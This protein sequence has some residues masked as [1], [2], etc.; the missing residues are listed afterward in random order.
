MCSLACT[1]SE[2]SSGRK[3][4]VAPDW[5][6]QDLHP[7]TQDLP[8]LDV[9]SGILQSWK[10]NLLLEAPP[11][12][13][14][15]TIVP[16]AIYHE[17]QQQNSDDIPPNV[18]V[19]E[20]RRVAVRSAATRMAQLLNEPVG[21]TVGYA[22]RGEAKI[23]PTKTRIIVMTDGVLLNRLQQDPELEG[24]D[25]VILDEFHERGVGSDTCLA[26]CR[27]AQKLFRRDLQ[28]VVM[29]ATLLGSSNN[30]IETTEKGNNDDNT[31][32][33]PASPY[34][35]LLSAL[36]GPSECHVVQSQGRQYAIDIIWG[37]D[38]TM[39]TT[40]GSSP[41][42]MRLPLARLKKD[43]KEL[44]KLMCHAILQAIPQSRGGDILVFLP[45]AAEIRNVIR[46]LE[47]ERSQG[48]GGSSALLADF[49]IL[50]LYGALSKEAQDLA[51]SSS[52][53]SDV[54]PKII[55]SSP[56]AEAS[57][58]LPKVTC[59]VDSGLRRE[60]RCDVDTGMP[61]LVTT[62]CSRASAIQR[63]GRAGRVQEGICLRI[64]TKQ[65]WQ[66]QMEEYAPPE[67]ASTDL[68][69]TLL[70]LIRWGCASKQE[71]LNDLAF[72]DAP[73]EDTL[74]QATRLL[75]DL[76]CLEDD[77]ATDD[78]KLVLTETGK[79]VSEVPTHPRLATMLV[80]ASKDPALL[81]GAIAVAFLMDDE[82]GTSNNGNR[83]SG[84]NTPDLAKRIQDLYRQPKSSQ[85]T[86]QLLKYASRTMGA[87]GRAAVQSVMDGETE[88]LDVLSN[89]G[90]AVLPGF[91]DLVAER[92]GDASYG[93]STYLLS[94]GRSARL[95]DIQDASLQ[96]LV[97]LDTSTGDDGKTRVRSY[98][99]IGNDQ[100]QEVAV[101]KEVCYAV[102]SKGY[103]IRAKQVTVVGSLEL[104]SKPLPAPSAEQVATMLQQI[105]EEG[106][107]AYKTLSSTMPHSK[108]QTLDVLL[109]RLKLARHVALEIAKSG[110]GS[111]NAG[112]T[113]CEDADWY[114]HF[115]SEWPKWMVDTQEMDSLLDDWWS[116][117]SLRSLKDL[118]LL[119]IV[120]SSLSATALHALQ[121]YYPEQVG[122]PDGTQIPLV[123][124]ELVSVDAG[125]NDDDDETST[126]SNNSGDLPIT[127]LAK[128]KLQQFFGTLQTPTIGP[129]QKPVPIQIQLLSPANRLL[130]QTKDLEFFWSEV[131]PQV[132]TEMK[133]KYPKH[134]W[135]DDPRSA[136]ATKQSKK[137]QQKHPSSSSTE[138]DGNGK[139]NKKRTGRK[140]R[141]K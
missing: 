69:S 49:H 25:A 86:K 65:E 8:I 50:P 30:N 109:A 64:Y 23:H 41:N 107:G 53:S 112:I 99:P 117:G 70:L 95:E 56:I 96:Y 39:K 128:A 130:A 60:P 85:S 106:G 122:A 20:P 75:V 71:V 81:A 5:L 76:G 29:S 103:E 44:T 104:S 82:S 93:G 59:V 74:N 101:G 9:L 6:D 88:L 45:G 105:V 115:E 131:Y 125:D 66:S 135:P 123:Y 61:R 3:K 21:K 140:K 67:I 138:A 87:C 79:A 62:V 137:Q 73:Q 80:R 133:G 31:N 139:N 4:T 13:G 90:L 57:L 118:D 110:S 52:P 26:L 97:V 91:V 121:S 72:V 54:T 51:I 33:T 119:T 36:G 2:A 1:T 92:K 38:M 102:P 10:P 114:Q 15:T 19:V 27:E 17:L 111:E 94:L 24:V 46:T 124:Q 16:L 129:P 89:L 40:I 34:A 127:V 12:A 42:L 77:Y 48:R 113:E 136:V 132:R 11:G 63:A 134:P 14:K 35:N 55:V 100:L 18:I 141:K 126:S 28:L 83:G 37:N 98:V 116:A 84:F 68:S 108:L 47:K 32:C 78:D 43:R 7:S 22:M 120:Q 58:T